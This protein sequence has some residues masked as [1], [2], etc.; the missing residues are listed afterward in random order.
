ML[1]QEPRLGVRMQVYQ[2]YDAQAEEVRAM[3]CVR[4][5][6]A[7]PLIR[8][9]IAKEIQFLEKLQSCSDVIIRLYSH[10]MT[11]SCVLMVMEC[12]SIDLNSWLNME[13]KRLK[14]EDRS[15]YWRNMVEAVS[16][17][18][19]QGVVHTDLKPAN[20][21]FVKGR[22][23]LIDFGIANSIQADA[24]S[25]FRDSRMGTL[26]FMAPETIEDYS[27]SSEGI[28]KVGPKSDV[29]ALGCILFLMTY[30]YTPFQKISKHFQKLHAIIDPSHEITFPPCD[31]PLLMDVLKRSL[32]RNSQERISVEEI[33]THP[34][35]TARPSMESL[36]PNSQNVVMQN[37][38][39]RRLISHIEALSSPNSITRMAKGLIE[40]LE[41]RR[42]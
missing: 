9:A 38:E 5:D 15:F 33:L 26:N 12:G 30:G 37:A 18:H 20:F 40:D 19:K 39:V 27:D 1:L 41:N 23:K 36:K 8:E 14:P 24:T 3:K 34:Y 17:I 21:L 35:L 11:D 42:K 25:F 16:T 29:W 10:E 28:Y 13:R 4:L 22:L 2:V 7:D 31:E 6:T 32:I